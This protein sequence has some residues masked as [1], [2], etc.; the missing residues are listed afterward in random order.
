MGHFLPSIGELASSPTIGHDL[1]VYN[2]QIW[3]AN[4]FCLAEIHKQMSSRWDKKVWRVHDWAASLGV[5]VAVNVSASHNTNTALNKQY[6]I[7]ID[8]TINSCGSLPKQQTPARYTHI[9]PPRHNQVWPR[10]EANGERQDHN[11]QTGSLCHDEGSLHGKGGNPV[12]GSKMITTYVT[13]I[14]L[15]GLDAV[16]LNK[17]ETENLNIF[18]QDL[19]RQIQG[20]Y[21]STANKAVYLLSG[22]IP[23]EADLH[24]RILCLFGQVPRQEGTLRD[25][26]LRQLGIKETNSNSW[27]MY[28]YKIA[29]IYGIDLTLALQFPWKKEAW[30]RYISD[31]IDN[32]RFSSL[33]EQIQHYSTLSMLLLTRAYA[34]TPHIACGWHLNLPG[35]SC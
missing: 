11:S 6:H 15:Y 22:T 34:L 19:L 3:L 28:V 4:R 2:M 16:V 13:P 23:V 31:N 35:Q 18:N 10:L 24:K 8:L 33:T 29:E 1:L 12:T 32:H 9:H 26:A 25:I 27:F 5:W 17:Q 14:L 20:L 21:D 7:A 30:S